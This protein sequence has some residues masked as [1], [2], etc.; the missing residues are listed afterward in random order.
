SG[1]PRR[2]QQ[3]LGEALQAGVEGF[4][5][6]GA[7]EAAQEFAATEEGDAGGAEDGVAERPT[8]VALE[9][10]GDDVDVP[11]GLGES[12][13][14]VGHL[15]RTGVEGLGEADGHE[16]G[17]GLEEVLEGLLLPV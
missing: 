2:R 11:P 13:E 14:A 16:A 5:C 8:P 15:L 10:D 3:L 1:A 12:L 9:A 4:R 17:M 6:E 7:V